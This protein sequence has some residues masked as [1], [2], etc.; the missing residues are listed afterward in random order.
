M[1]GDQT[2]TSI[3]KG[4]KIVIKEMF[5]RAIGSS[6]ITLQ[7]FVYASGE[8]NKEVIEITIDKTAIQGILSTL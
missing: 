7:V 6:S 4:E 1:L 8:T 3:D 2:L 5:M